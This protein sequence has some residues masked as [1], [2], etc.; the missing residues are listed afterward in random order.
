MLHNNSDNVSYVYDITYRRW[1]TFD[2]LDV[3]SSSLLTG[4]T[5]VENINLAK[6]LL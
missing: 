5:N 4:G 1:T 2:G 3:I 6:Q